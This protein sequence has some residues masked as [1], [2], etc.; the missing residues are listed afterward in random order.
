MY[1]P[2]LS[3][4]SIPIL[5][6]RFTCYVVIEIVPDLV[7]QNADCHLQSCHNQGLPV[8]TLL[9]AATRLL[10]CFPYCIARQALVLFFFF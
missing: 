10:R 9:T 2:F 3:V 1:P 7:W 4:V 8:A 6:N 5:Q